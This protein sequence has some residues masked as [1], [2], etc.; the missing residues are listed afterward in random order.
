MSL[1]PESSFLCFPHVY[2]SSQVLQF[3]E[4]HFQIPPPFI[5]EKV[6]GEDTGEGGGGGL[7]N[8]ILSNSGPF[9]TLM[10]P[11]PFRHPLSYCA[12]ITARSS[13]ESLTTL[14]C[15][16]WG[17]PSSIQLHMLDWILV[18]AKSKDSEVY[19][20]IYIYRSYLRSL[21]Y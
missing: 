14:S 13:D 18:Y 16:C 15:C 20:Y 10:T 5:E 6:G 2:F 11:E 8:L 19:I 4:Y 9:L 3:I 1:N 21:R 7:I 17:L 12:I